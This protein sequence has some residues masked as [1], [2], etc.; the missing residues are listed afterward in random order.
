MDTLKIAWLCVLFPFLGVIFTFLMAKV[1]PRLRNAAAVF[2][3]FLSAVASLQLLTR[4]FHPETLPL[5]SS[6]KWIEI[7][8]V[9]EFGVL[10][11]PLSIILAVVVAVISFIIAVYCLGY[12]KGD[13]GITRFLMLVNLFIG[14]M[15]LLVLSNNLVFIFVGWKLV[16]LC[17]YALIG[18]YYKDEKKYWIGGPAPTKMVSPS[19][20]GLKA[21]VVTGIGDLVMLGGMLIV[22]YYARTFNVMELYTTVSVW[23]PE[24]A[25]TPG[26]IILTTVL[27]LAGPIGKSAQFPFHEWLP[28]AMAGPGPVSALIHAATMVKS[29]VYLVARF[30]PMFYYGYWV[31]G[32]SEASA[33]FTIVAW[34]GAITAFVAATQGMVALELKKALAFSTVSQIGY[35]WIGL[36]MA[37]LSGSVLLGGTTSGIFHLVSHAV[38][39]A[40]LF[41]CAGS[42]IHSAHSIYM[43]DMGSM[44]KYMPLT[45]IFMLIAAVCLMGIPPLPGFYSKDAIL[46]SALEAHQLPI[47]IIAVI[48]VV[49]TAFYTTRMV[50][51]VFYGPESKQIKHIKQE[52]GHIHEASP[53]M[54]GACGVLAVIIIFLGLVGPHVEHLLKE[55]FETNL[56]GT[57]ALPLVHGGEHPFNYHTLVLVLS[58][59]SILLGAI[60]A[61]MMYISRKWDPKAM[62]AGS[63]SLQIF[64]KFFWNRWF[65]DAFYLKVFVDGMFKLADFVAYTVEDWFDN[66]VHRRIPTLITQRCPAVMFK[67]RTE[68]D[69][70]LYNISYVVAIFVFLLFVVLK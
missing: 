54:W 65:I 56:V 25:K 24:M 31:A 61:Y 42:V 17:S 12:M 64:H 46:L 11:D 23:M 1:H 5:E 28:E 15:L 8:F 35:M 4:L 50:G 33:F 16:G 26:M 40:C 69:D 44:R 55:G 22:F 52:G 21:L 49:L 45:W 19:H 38:F 18:Y 37:G 58:I 7:P 10:V 29:G 62:V 27:L 9:V 41:L 30:I 67:L 39:K 2:F 34:V 51:M 59:G 66:L 68:S 20:C 57:L 3:P 53:T 14:S 60:P 70:L 63:S 32:I 47:F 43:N 36:G 48:T 6:V 13:P